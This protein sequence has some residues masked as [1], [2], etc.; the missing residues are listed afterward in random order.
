MGCGPGRFWLAAAARLPADLAITLA[1]LSPGMLAEALASVRR[2]GRWPDVRGDVADVCALPFADASFDVV[3][4]MHML[5]HA[6]DPDLAVREIARVLK[7]GGRAI[8]TTNGAGNLGALF[9][10]HWQAFGAAAHDPADSSFSLET[11]EPILR[12]H[13]AGVR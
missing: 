10:L 4:A 2:L 9:E 7:P 8:V 6:P 1:D 12:R 13:F 5:Y 3:L 11:G